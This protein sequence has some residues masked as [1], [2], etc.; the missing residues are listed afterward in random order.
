MIIGVV[1]VEDLVAWGGDFVLPLRDKLSTGQPSDYVPRMWQHVMPNCTRTASP[2]F[3]S[4]Y[5]AGPCD[6][7]GL[8][9]ETLA[10][11]PEAWV[12]HESDKEMKAA[13]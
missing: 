2:R 1:D 6:V 3:G 4:D 11:A 12:C 8:T 10:E 7:G 5:G 13:H 9:L